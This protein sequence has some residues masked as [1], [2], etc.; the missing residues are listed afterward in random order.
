MPSLEAN[1]MKGSSQIPVHFKGTLSRAAAA[2]ML[3]RKLGQVKFSHCGYHALVQFIVPSQMTQMAQPHHKKYALVPA[4]MLVEG[5]RTSEAPRPF[6]KKGK[7]PTQPVGN[8]QLLFCRLIFRFRSYRW[9]VQLTFLR[10]LA[11]GLP[12]LEVSHHR[13]PA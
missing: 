5:A 3:L 4:C 1:L 11:R 6:Q 12:A 8:L 2:A 9:T 10:S 7:D 13:R